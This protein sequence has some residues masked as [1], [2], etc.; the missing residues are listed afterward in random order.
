MILGDPL[1]ENLKFQLP[2]FNTQNIQTY[3]SEESLLQNA[4][5][6][7]AAAAAAVVPHVEA[8]PAPVVQAPVVEAPP[9][10]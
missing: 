10:G 4:A 8:T 2:H 5:N 6:A 7:K 1:Q 3:V 9:P